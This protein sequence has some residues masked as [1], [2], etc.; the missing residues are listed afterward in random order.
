MNEAEYREHSERVLDAWNRQDVDA[1]VDCYTHD[2]VYRDPNTDGAIEGAEAMR[3][4][5]TKLFANW[6]MHWS[7][8]EVFLFVEADGAAVLWTA[9]LR[10]KVGDREA[11]VDGMDLVVMT[12]DRI[13]RNEVYFD[14][15]V[16]APVFAPEAAPVS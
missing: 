12:G 13:A 2:L 8:R 16:L 4:Y 10:P 5:L 3:G 9:K 7:Q 6:Q 1:V 14:R 15:A 11:T